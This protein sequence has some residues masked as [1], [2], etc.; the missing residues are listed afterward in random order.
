MFSY[1][2]NVLYFKLPEVSFCNLST[3]VPGPCAAPGPGMP[4][5][6]PEVIMS[7]QLLPGALLLPGTATAFLAC[8]HKQG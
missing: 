1:V 8:F 3:D 7:L 6:A 5:P 2:P 4:L